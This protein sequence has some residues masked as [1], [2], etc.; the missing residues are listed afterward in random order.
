MILIQVLFIIPFKLY[1]LDD[2]ICKPDNT[3]PIVDNVINKYKT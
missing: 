2:I 3:N 1:S